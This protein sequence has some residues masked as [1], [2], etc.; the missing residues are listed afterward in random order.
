MFRSK[1]TAKRWNVAIW[2]SKSF[3]A[4]KRCTAIVP[5]RLSSWLHLGALRKRLV[6]LLALPQTE[7]QYCQFSGHGHG[8][9]LLGSGRSIGRQIKAISAQSALG[10]EGTED[11]LRCANEQS[12]QVGITALGNAQLRIALS[13]LI[14]PRT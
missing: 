2:L 11:V 4:S 5:D 8:G 13:A 1:L 3:V 10:S 9:S 12:A 14:T 6:G 7:Q